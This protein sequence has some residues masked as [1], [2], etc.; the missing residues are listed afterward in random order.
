MEKFKLLKKER[1]SKLPKSEGVYA[2][3]RGRSFLYIGKAINIGER[4][5]NHFRSPGYKDKFFIDQ[6][7]KI[8]YIKKHS[9]IEALILEANLIKKYK[10]KY[11]IVWR[12]DK[13]FFYVGIT[14]E[15][16]PRVFITH[17]IKK[18]GV[19]KKERAKYIGP[20]V[21]GTALKKTLKFLRRIFPY[22]TV[23]KHPKTSCP[24]CHLAMCPGPNTNKKEYK[25]DIKSLVSILKGKSRSVLKN[26]KREMKKASDSQNYEKAAQVKNQIMAFERVILNAKVIED[27]EK[28]QKKWQEIEKIFKKILKTKGSISRIEAYDVSNIQGQKATG[29]MVTFI[30]GKPEKN[31]YRKFKIKISGKPNDVAM[32][33]EVLSRRF[34]HSEWGLPDLILIDGGKAQ[35]N[36]AL[37]VKN[38]KQKIKSKIKVVSL[39][40]KENRLYIEKRKR[41]L[42]LNNLPREISNLILQLRDEAHR[43]AISY[44]RKLR[45]KALLN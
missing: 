25:K 22:Y 29:S 31:F 34:E 15:D 27:F 4:V 3:K 18:E 44:H 30:K 13:K 9:E 33:K 41:P 21:E 45:E 11:N 6:V 8:G 26:L 1:L 16:L 14:K 17:Q 43:F 28:K 39:A 38:K 10:P 40:K 37:W 24:W 7:E 19:G 32:I 35:L 5:K 36:V 42:L 20:F 23:K 2:L 12:D